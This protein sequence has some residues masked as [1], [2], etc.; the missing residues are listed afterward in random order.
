MV[1]IED[2]ENFSSSNIFE[3]SAIVHVHD[4]TDQEEVETREKTIK[5]T[6][7]D[8]NAYLNLTKDN[9]TLEYNGTFLWY[10][11]QSTSTTIGFQLL[12]EDKNII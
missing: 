1:I 11:Y 2:I 4:K 9:Q 5:G 10:I 6:W 8:K 7:V 12:F 3:L